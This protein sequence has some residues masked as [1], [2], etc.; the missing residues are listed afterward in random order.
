[1]SEREEW[2]RRVITRQLQH[3]YVAALWYWGRIAW[4]RFD[5]WSRN[6]T[7]LPP[8]LSLTALALSLWN[9]CR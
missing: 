2:E 9:A 8:W 1:M 4:V 6:H 5:E 3:R 7:H